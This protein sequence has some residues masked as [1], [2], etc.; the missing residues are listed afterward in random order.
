MYNATSFP[1]SQKKKRRKAEPILTVVDW[2][3]WPAGL[4][5]VD[6]QRCLLLRVKEL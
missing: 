1:T 3:S 2:S 5:Q 6:G 4:C